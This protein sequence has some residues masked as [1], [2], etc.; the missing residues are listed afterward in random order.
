[1][2]RR[3][4]QFLNPLVIGAAF[5]LAGCAASVPPVQVT[6]FHLN[7]Q[8]VPGTVAIDT[9]APGVKGPEFLHF[10]NAVTAELQRLGFAPAAIGASEYVATV[11]VSRGTREA[12]ARRASSPVSVGVGGSTGSFGSG[13]GVGVG[14]NF[15]G[16]P[17]DMIVSELRVQLKR[18]VGSDVIWEGRAQTEAKENAPAAQ[19]GLAAGKL[20]AALFKDFPGR[21]GETITV[22]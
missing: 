21:S 14:F 4:S 2:Y 22:P 16:R 6:R 20:A 8:V 11:D 7:E 15:G 19:P 10:T 1:M 9:A 12:L 17:R 13:V 18:R 3:A 5:A